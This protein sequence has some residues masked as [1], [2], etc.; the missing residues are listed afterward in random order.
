MLRHHS[1]FAPSLLLLKTDFSENLAFCAP[2]W[3]SFQ[4]GLKRSLFESKKEITFPANA[5]RRRS[6]Q[7][8]HID[9]RRLLREAPADQKPAHP[10][11]G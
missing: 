4:A 7:S 9:L 10:H 6:G 2:A 5:D 1:I 8:W 11:A 3:C